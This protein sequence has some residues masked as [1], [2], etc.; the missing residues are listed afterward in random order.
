MDELYPNA[1]LALAADIPHLAP[2]ASLEGA[3]RGGMARKR[4]AV[5]GSEVGVALALDEAGRI[6]A[7]ALEVE[8]CALGQASASVFARGALGADRGEV[9]AGRAAVTAVLKEGA[10]PEPGRFTAIPELTPIHGYPRRHASALLAW[11]AA[12]EAF[13]LALAATPTASAAP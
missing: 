6:A 1:L 10:A 12:A 3:A 2:L 13:D 11:R 7:L 5:C 8:A 4:S 9:E